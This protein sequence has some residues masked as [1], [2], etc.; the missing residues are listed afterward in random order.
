MTNTSNT[1]Y[2]ILL[3]CEDESQARILEE[4]LQKQNQIV[5][6]VPVLENLDAQIDNQ[7]PDI[8]VAIADIPDA[9]L[10]DQIKNLTLPVVIFSK[11]SRREKIREAI[12][13]G[14][15]SYVVDG[16]STPRILPIV[17]AAMSRFHETNTLKQTLKTTQN[18]LTER[19]LIDRAKGLIMDQ[20][21]CTEDEAYR[22]L[23]SMAM[24]RKKRLG[25]VARDV[26]E[27]SKAF[28]V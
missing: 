4:F 18:D 23:R 3:I 26:L 14:V 1:S 6:H 27:L 5:Y 21:K 12:Q 17:E 10:I 19:K 7:K 15:A 22:T 13:A 28:T 8:I 2:R 20:R 16:L 25:E 9:Y 24:D 11:D